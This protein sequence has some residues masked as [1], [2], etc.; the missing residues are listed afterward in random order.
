MK[1]HSS[2]NKHAVTSTQIS[3]FTD[4]TA[5][6]DGIDEVETGEW[7]AIKLPGLLFFCL[8]LQFDII[9]D[10]Q[11]TFQQLIVQLHY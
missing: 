2:S 5:A 1:I 10:T 7:Q 4:D 3:S 6:D 11:L 9:I 8:L